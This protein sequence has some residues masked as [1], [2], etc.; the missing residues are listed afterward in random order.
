VNVYRVT[1]D[2]GSGSPRQKY[3]SL[4]S[5][6]DR[7]I[8]RDSNEFQGK[9]YSKK[10]SPYAVWLDKP[11]LPRPDFF[12]YDPQVLCCTE[13]AIK[14]AGEPMETAGELLPIRIEGEKTKLWLLNITE[15]INVVDHKN[16]QWREWGPGGPAFRSLVTP[17]FRSERFGEHTSLFKIPEDYGLTIYCLE[18]SGDVYDGE[19]K[20]LVEHHG[21]TGLEFELIWTDRK[22][23]ARKRPKQAKQTPVKRR[24]R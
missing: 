20:A 21:L 12:A 18:R 1:S 2:Y 15:C 10:W 3:A 8:K 9:P 23:A 7:I 24:G 6:S 16:S 11:R 13:R 22:P 17:A 14:L 5:P 4:G 19:F